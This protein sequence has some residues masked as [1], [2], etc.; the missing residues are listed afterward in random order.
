MSKKEAGESVAQR[1]L[2]CRRCGVPMETAK[3]EF[4]YLSYNFHT[5]LPR[6]PVCHQVF[7]PEDLVKGRMAEVEAELEDK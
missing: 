1:D 7:I 6:C 3:T 2:L 5:E 4:S